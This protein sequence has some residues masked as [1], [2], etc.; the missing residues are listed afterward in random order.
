MRVEDN[1]EVICR[2]RGKTETK[3]KT[4]STTRTLGRKYHNKKKLEIG[5]KLSS[6][7]FDA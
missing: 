5:A 2:R 3:V 4:T 7:L 6:R 1:K